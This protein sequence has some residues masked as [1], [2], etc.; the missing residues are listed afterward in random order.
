V[1]KLAAN[2]TL[3]F[4]EVPFLDRFAA[5]RLFGFHGVEFLFPYAEDPV[6]LKSRLEAHG[7][8]MALFNS[9]PGD[10]AVGQRGLAALPGREGE[11]MAKFEIALNYATAL[12]CK[13][14]HFMAGIVPVDAD[15]RHYQDVFLANLSA[16]LPL[17]RSA[18]VQLL[19]EPL[20]P[21]DAPGYL[22]GSLGDACAVINAIND[23]AL[24][25]QY[26]FYHIQMMQGQLLASFK[27]HQA[28]I[29]HV[30]IAG[31]PGR[32]EPDDQQE[33]QYRHVVAAL[34]TMGY[35]GWIGCEYRPRHN[36]AEGLGWA[37]GYGIKTRSA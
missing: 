11:C 2:L 19:L 29:A 12:D 27:Q 20:N 22:I 21:I 14:M 35:A 26:D 5:A 24:R 13:L 15:R 28:A 23:P 37:S 31:V 8:T 10:F 32:H 16:A 1:P 25:L 3:L 4:N 33:I 7:L 17:A 6:A 18:G 9:W 34:D 30:Q 36:T